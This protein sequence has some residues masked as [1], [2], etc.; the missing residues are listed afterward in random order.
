MKKIC[1]IDLAALCLQYPLL[2][3]V[4]AFNNV[5]AGLNKFFTDFNGIRA[6]ANRQEAI[7][8]LREKYLAEV[9]AFPNKLN[10]DSKL[11][12][13]RSLIHI[14]LLEVL[15]S[16]SEFHTHL[17]KE[18]QKQVLEN[19]L[20]GYREKFKYP[21]YFAGSG[22][23]SNLYARAHLIIQI[24]PSLSELFEEENSTVLYYGMADENLINTIDSLS[25]KLIK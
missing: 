16:Y 7:P 8:Y 20:F 15:L 14:S 12:I 10:T 22:F 1:S 11:E 24:D 5:T 21:E 4:L 18:T 2:Y 3:D 25:Y 17:S 19:L 13:G 6:L 23:T 9:H